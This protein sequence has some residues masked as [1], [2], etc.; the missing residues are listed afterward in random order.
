MFWNV[1]LSVYHDTPKV[2]DFGVFWISDLCIRG[3]SGGPKSET[4]LAPSI[5]DKGCSIY[6][7]STCC[8]VLLPSHCGSWVCLLLR[9][10]FVVR[11]D[12]RTHSLM[13]PLSTGQ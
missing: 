12:E 8:L 1:K 10:E 11:K 9:I 2:L 4:L 7:L 6:M 13:D 3:C 5:L